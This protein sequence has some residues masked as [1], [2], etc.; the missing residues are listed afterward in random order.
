MRDFNKVCSPCAHYSEHNKA[1]IAGNE[2]SVKEFNKTCTKTNIRTMKINPYV[3][4][5]LFS[6]NDQENERRC[7]NINIHKYL[8]EVDNDECIRTNSLSGTEK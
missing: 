4:T 2:I 6:R 3:L 7:K 5:N 8:D 1:P